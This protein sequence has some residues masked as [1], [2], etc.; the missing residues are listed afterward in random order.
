MEGQ[1]KYFIE[2]PCYSYWL[3]STIGGCVM[4]YSFQLNDWHRYSETEAIVQVCAELNVSHF[5]NADGSC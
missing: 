1:L 5:V 2:M 3:L 4:S